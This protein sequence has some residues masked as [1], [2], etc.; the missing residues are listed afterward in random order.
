V[1]T[2]K[3]ASLHDILPV[4]RRSSK[5]RAPKPVFVSLDF[6]TRRKLLVISDAK[7]GAI[8]KAARASGTLE[9]PVQVDAAQLARFIGTLGDDVDVSLTASAN[10]LSI[11]AGAS[12]MQVARVDGGGRKGIKLRPV[13]PDK[14]HKGKVEMPH[15]PVAKRR[16]E[17]DTWGFSAH[18]PMPALRKRDGGG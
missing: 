4:V 5:L 2:L 18:V 9:G 12:R 10:H 3:A 17:N 6:D 7:H 11:A 1:L 16:A 13:E 15:D 14:R 8:E